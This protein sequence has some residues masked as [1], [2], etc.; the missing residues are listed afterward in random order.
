VKVE[1]AS[2]KIKK[3]EPRSPTPDNPQGEWAHCIVNGGKPGSNFD[4][5]A[6]L[7]EF[8]SLGNLAI[9]SGQSIEWD[10]KA[11][12]VTNYEAANRFVKRPA[13]RAGWV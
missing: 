12:K 9:R 7:A 8:V 1:M 4:Y 6:P 11:V 3:T 2:G 13:Y 5:A 10:T